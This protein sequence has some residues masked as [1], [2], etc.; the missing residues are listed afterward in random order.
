MIADL[1]YRFV[2]TDYSQVFIVDVSRKLE[3]IR[4]NT[5]VF[6][7]V[8]KYNLSIAPSKRHVGGLTICRQVGFVFDA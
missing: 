8:T 6:F 1:D 2:N 5:Y 3:T 4:K 7:Y